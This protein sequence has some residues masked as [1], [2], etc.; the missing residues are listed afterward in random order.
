[1]FKYSTKFEKSAPTKGFFRRIFGNIEFKNAI[2]SGIAASISLFVGAWFSTLLNRP[3]TL[4]S[5]LWCV[6]SAIVVLQAHIGG[7]Y[8]AAWERFLGVLI[9]SILGCTLFYFM[10]DN[11]LSLGVA[12]CATVLVCTFLNIQESVRIA[13]L[14]VA[15]IMILSSSHH[16]SIWWY[17]LYRF[18]DSCL[19]I[20]I[21]MLIAHILWPAEAT[22]KIEYNIAKALSSLSKLFHIAVDLDPESERH[23]KLFQTLKEEVNELL[24][25][26]RD[27]FEDARLEITLRESK[28]EDWNLLLKLLQESLDA[29]ITI[30]QLPK[31]KLNLILDDALLT[32]L[33]D[34]IEITEASFQQLS[35]AFDENNKVLENSLDELPTS[36]N[37]L[38]EDLVRFRG[39]RATRQFDW[40]EIEGFFVFFYSIGMVAE[41]IYR[42]RDLLPKPEK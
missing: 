34:F 21:A 5:G 33:K 38:K 20:F 11:P 10:G 19:G 30:K 35:W 31:S 25:D 3:D 9:G 32:K 16:I 2:K 36:F 27:N 39:T 37:D 6:V 18:L 28:L 40:K 7:T 1:M 4:I 22:E 41:E 13:C 26:S 42:I 14:T 8:R 12:I 24:V 23:E 15:V 29:I 17:G